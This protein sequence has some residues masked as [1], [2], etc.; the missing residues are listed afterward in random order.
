MYKYVYIYSNKSCTRGNMA[1]IENLGH[2]ENAN[3]EDDSMTIQEKQALVQLGI[4]V[5]VLIGYIF[6]LNDLI[7]SGIL[8]TTNDT[9]FWAGVLL[10]VVGIQIGANVLVMI[11]F[12]IFL[13]VI[14][15][16]RIPEKPDEL[17]KLIDQK[18]TIY[19][20]YVFFIGFLLTMAATTFGI[21]IWL[22]FNLMITSFF[23]MQFT[24]VITQYRLYNRGF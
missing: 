7:R 11:L 24:W 20:S 14:A 16:D 19:G 23:A 21:P 5:I 8:I 12:Y 6:Y 15:T 17:D 18:C 1:N 10:K 22:M 9:A 3:P 2:P 13:T 4:I